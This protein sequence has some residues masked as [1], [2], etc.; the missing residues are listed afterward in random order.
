MAEVVRNTLCPTDCAGVA[1]TVTLPRISFLS[2]GRLSKKPVKAGSSKFI[3]VSCDLQFTDIKDIA[4]WQTAVTEGKAICSPNG[5]VTFGDPAG[6]TIELDACGNEKCVVDVTQTITFTSYK[7]ACDGTEYQFYCDLYENANLYRIIPIG[8]DGLFELPKA[9]ADFANGFTTEAPTTLSVGFPFSVISM[10]KP[11]DDGNGRK[12]WSIEFEREL[13]EPCGYA[14][15]D[16]VENA[17][18]CTAT[19]NKSGA[20]VVEKK[21]A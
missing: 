9:W 20:K 6:T 2:D 11:Q 21:A 1:P 8:C 18:C 10:P 7:V 16:G 13:D 15:L 19:E 5:V 17:V 3:I 4:A 12:Q 14:V